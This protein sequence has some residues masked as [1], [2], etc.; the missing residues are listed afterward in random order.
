MTFTKISSK[1]KKIGTFHLVQMCSLMVLWSVNLQRS[2]EQLQVTLYDVFVIVLWKYVVISISCSNILVGMMFAY[3]FCQ[4]CL[5][6]SLYTCWWFIIP[7]RV[8][9]MNNL[10][11]SCLKKCSL[12]T[13]FDSSGIKIFHTWMTQLLFWIPQLYI[14][15]T[16][17]I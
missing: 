8:G 17:N 3:T 12:K 2:E 4:T 14:A 1:L 5:A 10:T 16:T 9:T 7:P 15:I 6:G 13:I 11:I